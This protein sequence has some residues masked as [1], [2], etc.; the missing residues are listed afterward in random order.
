M[1]IYEY[2]CQK[3]KKHHEVMQRITESPL[4]KCPDCGGKMKKKISNTSFVL[5]GTGWYAT[6]YASDKKKT[7]VS[8]TKADKTA[9]SKPE[10]KEEVKAETK[11]SAKEAAVSS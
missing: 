2:G 9:E 10:K 5:K 11:P 4:T 3:C 1:P 7:N 6:D 8:P